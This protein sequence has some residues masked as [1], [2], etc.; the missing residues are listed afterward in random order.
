MES[1][2]QASEIQTVGL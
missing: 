2:C 1:S